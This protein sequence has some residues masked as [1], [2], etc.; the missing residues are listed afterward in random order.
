MSPSK[1]FQPVHRVAES[2]ENKAARA[3]GESQRKMREHTSRLEEL[4]QYHREYME[5]FKSA[6]REGLTASQMQE[7]RAFLGK[8]ETA[9]REQEKVL[10][11]SHREC[12][13]KK[14][15]WQ[16]KH[17][18]TQALGKAMDRFRKAENKAMDS[19]EQ[20]A[21]DEHSQ[22]RNKET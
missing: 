14:D 21:T 12:T 9:I 6:S 18:R 5:R 20:Q 13:G 19:R 8:L 4:K 2:R 7:Y 10:Q 16:E 3:L 11:T 17:V 22:W 15:A 1:R